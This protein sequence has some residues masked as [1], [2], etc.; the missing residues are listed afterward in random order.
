M[1]ELYILTGKRFLKTTVYCQV[2]RMGFSCRKY[3]EVANQINYRERCAYH[4]W[5]LERCFYPEMLVTIDETSKGKGD[6]CRDQ[7]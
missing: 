4:L 3:F 7:M 2:R 1:L 5:I 6:G